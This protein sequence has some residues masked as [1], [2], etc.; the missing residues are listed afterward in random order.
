MK[1]DISP[2]L[3]GIKKLINDVMQTPPDQTF[4][5]AIN[6][7]KGA[8]LSIGFSN[9]E[10]YGSPVVNGNV[11]A[12]CQDAAHIGEVIASNEVRQ[13]ANKSLD[14]IDVFQRYNAN[15]K[16]YDVLFEKKGLVSDALSTFGNGQLIAPWNVSYF[17]KMFKQPLLYSNA[18]ELVK[19]Y[20]GDNPW[21][22]VMNMVVAGYSGFSALNTS[23]TMGN[24]MNYDVEAAVGGMTSQII[25]MTVTYNISM[26]ET[27]ASKNSQ[28]PFAGQLISAK[29]K[30]A[31]YV[32]RLIEDYLIY[33]GYSATGTLGI[34]NVNA[35]PS[36]SGSSLKTIVGGSS[37]TKG[38]DIANEII[39]L[40]NSFMS[41]SGNKFN[42]VRIALSPYSINILRSIGYSAAYNPTSPM[43]IIYDNYM[44]ES[45][46]DKKLDIQFV[47]DPLLAESTIF[48][49]TTSDYIILSAPEITGDDVNESQDLINWGAPLE[50]FVYPA[51]PTAYSVQYK[52]LK[53]V[54]GIFAPYTGAIQAYTGFGVKAGA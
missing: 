22:E 37:T 33:Y 9:E 46:E 47:S 42:K 17:Q 24:T 2:K 18:K 27:E 14:L 19:I 28:N 5:S 12:Y 10:K 36:Y 41:A 53:R 52:Q 25:N 48:N 16:K 39:S 29:Q 40:I 49:V 34:L 26:E 7:L 31:D 30:Y 51:I 4:R 8:T 3:K 45:N 38:S 23:G 50:R 32:L 43:K 13:L 44:A 21:A 1:L 54:A 20:S 6:A 11:Q 15:S 35:V